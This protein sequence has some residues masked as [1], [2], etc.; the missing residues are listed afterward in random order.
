MKCFDIFDPIN[1]VNGCP[2]FEGSI[3]NPILETLVRPCV[4]HMNTFASE[5]IGLSSKVEMVL[6]DTRMH[7]VG[8]TEYT[9]ELRT[10]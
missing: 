7:F 2:E 10:F 4:R 8:G 3:E 9:Y 6:L 5:T 1:H